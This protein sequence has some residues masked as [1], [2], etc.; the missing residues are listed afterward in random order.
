MDLEYKKEEL[1]T[2][3]KE[4]LIERILLLQELTLHYKGEV[5][6]VLKEWRKTIDF[7]KK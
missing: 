4:Y 6:H 2:K 5:K 7:L 1:E 3:S